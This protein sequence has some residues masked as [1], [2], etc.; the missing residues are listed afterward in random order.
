M[1][2]SLHVQTSQGVRAAAAHKVAWNGRGTGVWKK[3]TRRDE[4]RFEV[5]AYTEPR[6]GAVDEI[7]ECNVSR[8][9]QL[10]KKNNNP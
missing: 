2:S 4:R 8:S 10:R 7:H 9:L 6:H 3:E 1:K 5:R